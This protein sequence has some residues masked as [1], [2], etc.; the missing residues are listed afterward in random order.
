MPVYHKVNKISVPFKKQK[1]KAILKSSLGL[2]NFGNTLACLFNENSTLMTRKLL[3][4]AHVYLR[5][6][7][8]CEISVLD[9]LDQ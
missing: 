1:S 5:S 9:P 3:C 6:F 7:F 2:F 4:A 8:S